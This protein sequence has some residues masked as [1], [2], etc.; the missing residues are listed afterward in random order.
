VIEFK[1]QNICEHL[2]DIYN[3]LEKKKIENFREMEKAKALK[4]DSSDDTVSENKLNYEKKK[5]LDRDLRK[6]KTQI[7][8]A[9]EEIEKLE[10]EISEMD[11]KLANPDNYAKEIASG[12]LYK[13]YDLLKQKLVDA[14]NL[15]ENLEMEADQIESNY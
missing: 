8:K 2:G 15:W 7:K 9:E 13:S 12:E 5:Q 6:I 10:A 1:D 3:F 14:M 11:K 4:A